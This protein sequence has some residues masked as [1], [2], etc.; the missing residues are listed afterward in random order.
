[1]KLKSFFPRPTKSSTTEYINPPRKKSS[2]IRGTPSDALHKQIKGAGS[3]SEFWEQHKKQIVHQ[4][5]SEYLCELLDERGLKRSEVVVR[6][7]LDKAYV[8]QIFAGKK[9]PS[10]DKLITIALGMEF[11]EE[12][13]QRMLQLSGHRELW[14]KDERD[15]LLLF[16]IQRGMSLEEVHTELER[17]G[18]DPLATPIK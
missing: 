11:S 18:L 12:E 14:P 3:F 1:M 7:G 15:A 16:A 8:Y 10:R 5:L 13:T 4:P 9:N 2:L 17:Y 6:T